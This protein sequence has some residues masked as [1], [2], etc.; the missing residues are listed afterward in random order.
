MAFGFGAS[1]ADSPIDHWA[2]AVGGRDRLVA[3]KSIYREATL[4]FGPYTGTI[5]VWHT[6][7]GRYRKE[8][9][10]ANMSTIETFDGTEGFV[11]QGEESAR[12]MTP[13]EAAVAASKRFA[14]SNALFFVFFPE[15]RRGTVAVE[16]ENTVVLKPEGGIGWLVTLDQEK[17]LP[18]TMV[19]TEGGQTVTVSFKEYETVDGYTFEKEIMRAAGNSGQSARIR[20]TKTVVNPDVSGVRFSLD[21]GTGAS[22]EAKA[23]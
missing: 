7:D 18:K 19:H 14:N 2:Q 1:G 8:E 6:A 12:K 9:Q 21:S 5:K 4:E 3:L 11:Q 17:W 10:I 16:G 20:F 22:Q 23:Q 15:R 13:L